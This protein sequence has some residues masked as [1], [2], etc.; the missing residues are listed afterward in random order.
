MSTRF[1]A[2]PISTERVIEWFEQLLN[3]VWRLSQM[4]IFWRSCRSFQGDVHN[5]QTTTDDLRSRSSSLKMKLL[6]VPVSSQSETIEGPD[7]KV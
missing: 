6:M 1:S 2:L 4:P 3:R 7:M 5:R